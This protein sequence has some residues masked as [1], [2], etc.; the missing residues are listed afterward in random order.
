MT[1][2]EVDLTE[3][4]RQSRTIK[5]R[6]SFDWNW[7]AVNRPRLIL[8][9]PFDDTITV[10]LHWGNGNSDPVWSIDVLLSGLL[11][12]PFIVWSH[13]RWDRDYRRQEARKAAL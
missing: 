13:R 6:V 9:D 5:D 11:A 7:W 8:C 1:E 3:L 2:P 4:R 12:K 10:G